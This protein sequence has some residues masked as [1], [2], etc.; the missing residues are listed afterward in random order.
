MQVPLAFHG[1][2]DHYSFM[3]KDS[4]QTQADI[5]P[6]TEQP[7]FEQAMI[8]LEALVLKIET[9]NLSLEDSLIEFEK[10]IKLSRDCQQALSSAEQRVKILS[11][12]GKEDD[13]I[14]APD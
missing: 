4:E 12:D 3:K 5:I 11:N 8:E 2:K 9:G 7:P 14:S 1:L 13:F 10:G 6:Q